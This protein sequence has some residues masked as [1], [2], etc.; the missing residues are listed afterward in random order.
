VRRGSDMA[1]NRDG[2]RRNTR[3]AYA[4]LETAGSA[5]NRP[6]PEEYRPELWQRAQAAQR[7]IED[8]EA[9]PRVTRREE[10]RAARELG[11]STRHLRRWRVRYRALGT[12]TAFLPQR[13]GRS[14]GTRSLGPRI[15]ALIND[16]ARRAVKR[17]ADVAVDDL[18]PLIVEGAR[19]LRLRAPARSTVARR[20]ADLKRQATNFDPATER[21]LSAQR[22]P[23]RGRLETG[24][25]LSVVQMDHTLAD[26]IIVDPMKRRAIG[27][28]WLTL[29]LDVH[30]RMV[31]GMLV[32]LEAPSGLSVALTLD[33]A[34]YPKDPWAA[35]IGLDLDAFTAFGLMAKLHL[36]NGP[37]FRAQGL[38]RGCQ[39]Y[40]IGLDHRPV[41]TPRYGG[42]IERVIGTMMG[43]VKLLPGA[44]MSRILHG[45]PKHPEKRA[46]FTLADLTL[47]LARQIGIYHH[48]VHGTLGTTPRSAWEQALTRGQAIVQP[49]TPADRK[50][51]AIH[52]LPSVL[53]TVSRE[54]IRSNSL[55]YQSR[56]LEPLIEPERKRRVR[57][58]PRDLSRVFLETEKRAL[59]EVPL[60]DPRW[61]VM[62]LWEWRE[63]RRRERGGTTVDVLWAARAQRDNQAL[64]DARARG[65]TA[66]DRRR[67]SR[68]ELWREAQPPK[69]RSDRE[70]T[71]SAELHGTPLYCEVLK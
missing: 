64:I 19:A 65:G 44:T 32:S 48:T 47:Y 28:P 60:A 37:E 57:F 38:E 36:D 7:V 62:S 56:D 50:A 68:G 30:T 10:A 69:L 67:R 66:R 40:G 55:R 34:V 35:D 51:F 21:A 14:P 31:L 33:H 2:R 70:L 45:R 54:G 29:A 17:S 12:L 4:E 11:V 22:A 23:V 49:R 24:G 46:A 3:R 58:D 43:N 5:P 27:R 59:L 41:G 42:A 71:V 61:P 8:L 53:R 20:L 52:F 15:E 13:P 16:E 6:A 9:L 63:I 25:A 26:V 18:Y 1:L 39:L